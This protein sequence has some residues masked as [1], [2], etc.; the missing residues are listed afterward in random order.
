MALNIKD[1]ETDALVRELA[2]RRNLS[3]TG[4]IKLAVSN[5]LQREE[6]DREDAF[7]ARMAAIR[8]IQLRV[9]QLPERMTAEEVEAWMYDENGLPH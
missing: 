2:V 8:D 6:R 7:D 3:F 1:E 4:A 5:E 9:A